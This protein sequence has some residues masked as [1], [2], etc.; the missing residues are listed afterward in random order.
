MFLY[1]RKQVRMILALLQRSSDL[2]WPKSSQVKV[3][4]ELLTEQQG[5]F[6]ITIT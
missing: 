3:R 5:S 6:K 4:S 2:P 1:Q